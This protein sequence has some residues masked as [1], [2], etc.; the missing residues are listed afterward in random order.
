MS[1]SNMLKLLAYDTYVSVCDMLDTKPISFTEYA[2]RIF[3]DTSS[4]K[5]EDLCRNCNH[6]RAEHRY[7]NYLRQEECKHLGESRKI[8]KGLMANPVCACHK[9]AIST[10]HEQSPQESK[11]ALNHDKTVSGD[12]HSQNKELM[13]KDYASTNESVGEKK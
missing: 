2:S 10:F 5:E 3:E 7:N 4:T 1:I 6:P 11:S 8:S 9:F 12:I 13:D